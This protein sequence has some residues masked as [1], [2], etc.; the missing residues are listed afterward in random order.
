MKEKIKPR[1][2]IAFVLM[3]ANPPNLGHIILLCSL[4]KTYKKIVV[5]IRNKPTVLATN[6]VAGVLSSIFKLFTDKYCFVSSDIDFANTNE[7]PKSKCDIITPNIKEYTNLKAKG[8]KD[9]FLVDYPIG[10][11]EG[12]HRIAYTRS[13]MLQKLKYILGRK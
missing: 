12:Y 3:N 5:L 9:V 6:D 7:I 8:C 2:K 1:N 10:Y 13:L 4:F 11:D